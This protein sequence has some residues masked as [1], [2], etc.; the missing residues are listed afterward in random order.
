MENKNNVL[1]LKEKEGKRVFENI[2]KK[3]PGF[4]EDLDS[5]V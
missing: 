4:G 5:E 1:F 2:K 3:L